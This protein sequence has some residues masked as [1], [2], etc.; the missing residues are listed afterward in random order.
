MSFSFLAA[1][2]L[3]G[4][5][6]EWFSWAFQE[7]RWWKLGPGIVLLLFAAYEA[8]KVWRRVESVLGI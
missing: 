5:S 8:S 6:Q 3:M 1:I 2:V 7:H 4:M